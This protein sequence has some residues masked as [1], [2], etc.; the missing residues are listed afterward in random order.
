MRDCSQVGPWTRPCP[1]GYLASIESQCDQDFVFA[2][3]GTEKETYL[4]ANDIDA[5]GTWTWIKSGGETF[6]TGGATPAG[7][8]GNWQD[9]EPNNG[10]TGQDCLV[11][12]V[13]RAPT[14]HPPDGRPVEGPDLLQG[15]QVPL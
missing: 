10:G 1:G 14:P 9:G 5:E 4:G 7:K 6:L 8:Y 3:L 12:G 2:M 11:I 15:Q 13:S